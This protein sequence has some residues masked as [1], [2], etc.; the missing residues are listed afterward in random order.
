LNFDKSIAQRLAEASALAY[1]KATVQ[2]HRTDAQALVI[3][4]VDA[5]IVAFRGSS[6]AQ[7]WL[8]NGQFWQQHTWGGNVHAGFNEALNDIL[9]HLFQAT[10]MALSP[11]VPLF[12][13]GHSLGGALAQLFAEVCARQDLNVAGV[14]TFGAPRVGDRAFA[15]HYNKVLGDR[16]FNVVNEYDVVPHLP[17]VGFLLK[18]W[19]TKS[20]VLLRDDGKPPVIGRNLINHLRNDGLM[21]F[22]AVRLL[23]NPLRF[24][25][26]VAAQHNLATYQGR[27]AFI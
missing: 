5:V 9:F 7:D 15:R 22:H 18:Y 16:T 4:D 6:S 11:D 21:L 26:T 25:S 12:V 20:E 19:R 24:W 1:K 8:Q 3:K 14:Y 23:R 2:A 10:R 27:L 13:T 17:L